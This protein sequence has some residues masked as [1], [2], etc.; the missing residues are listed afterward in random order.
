MVKQG[1]N[2]TSQNGGEFRG[3]IECDSWKIQDI[4]YLDA[5]LSYYG[6]NN[7][8]SSSWSD[9]A[10]YSIEVISLPKSQT[11][12]HMKDGWSDETEMECLVDCDAQKYSPIDLNLGY[13]NGSFVYSSDTED[14]Y[15]LNVEDEEEITVSF[16]SQC[17]SF[18]GT[19]GYQDIT[20][21]SSSSVIIE[22]EHVSI[23]SEIIS[24][25]EYTIFVEKVE[26]EESEGF[27]FTDE[28]IEL[29]KTVVIPQFYDR[30]M[31][32]Y[33]NYN[34]ET[35][36]FVLPL[37]LFPTDTA[38][39]RVEQASGKDVRIQLDY[40]YSGTNQIIIGQQLHEANVNVFENVRLTGLDGSEVTITMTEKTIDWSTSEETVI[41]SNGV[42]FGA[43]GPSADEG[44]DQNDAWSLNYSSE[45]NPYNHVWHS[46][47]L[48]PSISDVDVSLGSGMSTQSC[49]RTHYSNMPIEEYSSYYSS[50][51]PSQ[52][53]YLQQGRG[54][55]QL[56]TKSL[57]FMSGNT[58]YYISDC[59]SFT[60]SS[61]SYVMS[62][63]TIV[64]DTNDFIQYTQESF[65]ENVVP[66]YRL[67][68]SEYNLVYNSSFVEF[69]NMEALIEIPDD[70]GAEHYFLLL[71]DAE[72]GVVL[73][74]KT[75]YVNNNP[76]WSV[77]RAS[78]S[79]LSPGDSP[80]LSIDAKEITGYPLDW[81]LY[82][83][84]WNVVSSDLHQEIIYS[85]NLDDSFDGLGSAIID[86]DL[87]SYS[88]NQGESI[89]LSAIFELNQTTYEINQNWKYAVKTASLDCNNVVISDTEERICNVNFFAGYNGNSTS[90]GWEGDN[91][92]ELIIYNQLNL[93]IERIA[94][95]SDE[96]ELSPDYLHPIG[97]KVMKGRHTTLN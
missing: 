28:S 97:Q 70:D 76:T 74:Q 16:Y 96:G 27:V 12:S 85:E 88:L 77:S 92:G 95:E 56:E 25:C 61:A 51:I 79:L 46:F 6:N 50:D 33:E 4:L 22:T 94:F 20:Y 31:S 37:D 21:Q 17:S 91:Q 43:L 60:I 15:Y 14:W 69:D 32:N 1:L 29:G 87:P 63:S 36:N 78:S 86:L 2:Y 18:Q 67:Y 80:S 82:N 19:Y 65:K 13:N 23:P 53:V 73:T 68:D 75:I 81:Q 11:I 34:I 90:K 38:L 45:E 58:A 71:E 57:E 48:S 26:E 35:F 62:N 84:T 55:Y 64:V 3:E 41:R 8:Y 5:R 47:K 83:L 24:P 52:T 42:G 72:T 7:Q 40:S 10:N 30:F 59:P 49:V 44:M 66:Q 89:E 54:T 39:L 9:T 93:E